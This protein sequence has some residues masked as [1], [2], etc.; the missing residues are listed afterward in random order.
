[1]TTWWICGPTTR[2]IPFIEAPILWPSDMNIG[3]DPDAGEDSRQWEKR[4]AED[5]MAS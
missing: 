3:K 1:M 4:A 2:K 5:E